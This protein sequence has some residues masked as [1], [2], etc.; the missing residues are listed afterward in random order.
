MIHSIETSAFIGDSLKKIPMSNQERENIELVDKF[1]RK[2]FSQE[3]KGI[4]SFKEFCLEDGTFLTS[5]YPETTKI[6]QVAD[7][8][9]HFI[10]C[11]P[12]LHV[13]EYEILFAKENWVCARIIVEG[14][15]TGLPY[16][17]IKPSGKLVRRPIN[18]IYEIDPNSGKIKSVLRE[19]DKQYA[20]KQLGWPI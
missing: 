2:F 18:D 1:N 17:D 5:A 15:H 9:T 20:F 16:M 19:M 10:K 8:I 11:I 12:N 4:E 7:D 3:N 6:A 14:N 13:V